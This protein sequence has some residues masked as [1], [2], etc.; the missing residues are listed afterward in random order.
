MEIVSYILKSLRTLALGHVTD[1]V[2]GESVMVTSEEIKR[3]LGMEQMSS[4]APS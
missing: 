4:E 3:R 2:K 1:E